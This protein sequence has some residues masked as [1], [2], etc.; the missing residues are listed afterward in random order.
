MPPDVSEEREQ[1]IERET[2]GELPHRHPGRPV[3]GPGEFERLHQMRREPKQAPAFGARLEHET[4]MPVLEIA[5]AAVD[6]S[7]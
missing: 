5:N 4:K 3:D 6:Q 1:V 7:R 2:R